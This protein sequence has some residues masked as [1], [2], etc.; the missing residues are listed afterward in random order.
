MTYSAP[1]FRKEFKMSTQTQCK[2]GVKSGSISVWSRMRL[3]SSPNQ[4]PICSFCPSS[5]P[6]YRKSWVRISVSSIQNSKL[7]MAPSKFHCQNSV[8]SFWMASFLIALVIWSFC[9]WPTSQIGHQHLLRITSKF[10]LQY[11]PPTSGSIKWT[12]FSWFFEYA[13]LWNLQ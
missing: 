11:P 9:W 12:V 4:C 6:S 2:E 1:S 7:N 10:C 13:L 3:C 5:V 8:L